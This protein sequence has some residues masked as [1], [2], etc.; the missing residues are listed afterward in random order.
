VSATLYDFRDL[1][2]LLRL[3]QDGGMST[4]QMTEA[5][6][7]DEPRAVAN[8]FAWMR[9]YGMVDLDEQHSSWSVSRAGKRVIQAKLK[10]NEIAVVEKLPDETMVEVMAQVTSRYH[11]GE[12][13]IAHMLRREF[14]YGTQKR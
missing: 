9:R 10:A 8:R 7:I 4:K 1:D 5:L 12:A 13:M 6:G 2:L 11:R 14:L 3:A